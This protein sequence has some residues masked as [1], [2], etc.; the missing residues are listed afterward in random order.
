MPARYAKRWDSKAEYG[1]LGQSIESSKIAANVKQITLWKERL[2]AVTETADGKSE[3]KQ[4]IE[5]A[6]EN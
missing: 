3:F 2:G 4:T 5:Q 1:S 6:D